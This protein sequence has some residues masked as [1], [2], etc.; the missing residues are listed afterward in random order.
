MLPTIAGWNLE[1]ERGPDWVFVRARP[2][3]HDNRNAYHDEDVANFADQVWAVLEQSFTYR[4]VL[5]LEGVPLL[6]SR[7]IGQLV[8]LSKRVHSHNG[9]LRLSGLSLENQAVL[10]VCRLDN[11]LPCFESRGDAV[12]GNRPSQPR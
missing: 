3:D 2:H 5:E 6:H 8:R 1:V 10:H 11:A 9:V 7:L 4:L 12:N